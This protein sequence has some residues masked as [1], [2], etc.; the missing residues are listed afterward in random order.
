MISFGAREVDKKMFTFSILPD[1]NTRGTLLVM[2]M[3]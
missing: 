1:S 2:S 3:R